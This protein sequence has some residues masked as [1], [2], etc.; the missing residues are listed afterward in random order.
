MKAAATG[1]ELIFTQVKLAAELK[2]L[3]AI[4]A[5]FQRSRHKLENRITWLEK[6]PERAALE[7]DRWKKEIE[8]RDKNTT[9]ESYFAANGKIYDDKH[10]QELLFEIGRVMK[11]AGARPGQAQVV[12]KYRGFT[13]MVEAGNQCRQFS[14]KG[15]AGSYA[16]ASLNY[17]PNSEF[18][19]TGFIQRLDNYLGKFEQNIQDTKKDLQRQN[20]ELAI[21]RQNQGQ[22]FPQM[23]LLEALRQDNREVM[24]EL[25]ISQKDPAYKSSWKPQSQAGVAPIVQAPVY[26]AVSSEIQGPSR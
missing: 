5:T 11:T 8:L 20:A 14:L 12:G 9:R 23:I 13:V 1:N 25:Q 22:P 17:Q 21:A 19:I 16:P 10:R 3:E 15:A 7:I 26:H 6:A 2:K 4:H 18:S 24:R